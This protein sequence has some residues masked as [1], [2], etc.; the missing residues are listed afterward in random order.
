[1]ALRGVYYFK[2]YGDCLT[3]LRFIFCLSEPEF[4]PNESGSNYDRRAFLMPA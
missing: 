3:N 2:D 4:D 1:M